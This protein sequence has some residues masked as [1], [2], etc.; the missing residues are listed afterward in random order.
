MWNSSGRY[1]RN[2]HL[3]SRTYYPSDYSESSPTGVADDFA[4]LSLALLIW[5]FLVVV[6]G[7]SGVTAVAIDL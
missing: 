7:Y 4:E 1:R 2:S 5:Y 3:H 6:S